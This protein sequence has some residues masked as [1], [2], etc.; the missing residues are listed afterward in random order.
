MNVREPLIHVGRPVMHQR[1]FADLGYSP[2]G[3]ANGG[4][5][6]GEDVRIVPAAEIERRAVG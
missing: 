6:V 4:F 2:C 1:A 3:L 5:L